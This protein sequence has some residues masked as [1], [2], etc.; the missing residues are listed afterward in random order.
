M[1][2]SVVETRHIKSNVNKQSEKQIG[3]EKESHLKLAEVSSP[4]NVITSVCV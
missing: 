2:P 4:L 3:L 1:N